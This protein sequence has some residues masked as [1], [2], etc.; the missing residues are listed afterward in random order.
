[1]QQK[2]LLVKVTRI[3][4]DLGVEY[5][6]TGSYASSFQGQPRLTHDIDLL[7]VSI[8]ESAILAKLK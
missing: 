7:T 2:E 6:I 1:M 5:M 3:L 4:Q 8:P